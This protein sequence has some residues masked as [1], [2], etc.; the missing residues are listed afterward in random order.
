ME[1]YIVEIKITSADASNTSFYVINSEEAIG[2]FQKHKDNGNVEILED[3]VH[4]DHRIIKQAFLSESVYNEV[5][6]EL[7]NLGNY[8]KNDVS[9]EILSQGIQDI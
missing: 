4:S 5:K 7:E 9:I 3:T 8:K 6:T 2:I 1:K